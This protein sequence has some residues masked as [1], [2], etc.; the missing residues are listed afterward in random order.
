ML[1]VLVGRG[2]AAELGLAAVDD[3]DDQAR[4]PDRLARLSRLIQ[5][6]PTNDLL[7]ALHTELKNGVGLRELIAAGALANA[8]AFGGQD[9]NGYP[10][11]WRCAPPTRWRWPCP[12]RSGRCRSSR[13]S[14]APA[15]TSTALAAPTR[16][17]STRWSRSSSTTRRPPAS[18][19]AR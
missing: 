8:R 10:A 14:T 12:R 16:T 19:C 2:M 6:T 4:T 15:R 18:R 11:S 9:Y 17:T 7:P 3:A 5:Q 13:C 1:A